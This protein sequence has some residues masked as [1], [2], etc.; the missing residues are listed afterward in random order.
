MNYLNRT[1]KLAFYTA[2]KREGDVRYISNSSGY[3]PSHVRRM[4][5]GERRI[6]NDVADE[7]YFI[8]SY[9]TKNSELNSTY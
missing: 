5:S 7:A 9:R 6:N 1:A 3:S 8:S 4:L 2:R